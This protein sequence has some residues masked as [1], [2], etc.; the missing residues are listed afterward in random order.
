MVAYICFGAVCVLQLEAKTKKLKKVWHKLQGAQQEIKD[1][2]EEFQAEKEDMLDTIREL[3]KQLKLK[4]LLLEG[5]VPPQ[6]VERLEAR[7]VWDDEE[8]VWSLRRIELAGNRV[9]LR[10]PPSTLTPAQEWLL[11]QMPMPAVRAQSSQ[12]RAALAA[13]TANG[14]GPAT[15]D[16]EMRYKGENVATLDLEW[17]AGNTENYSGAAA[18][19]KLGVGAIARSVA[20]SPA[21]TVAQGGAGAGGGGGGA[22]R[23]GGGA[24][25]GGRS[26]G[27]GGGSGRSRG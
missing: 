4:Q 26:G 6:E 22:E 13:A 23:G 8:D 9:R 18:Q 2:K 16:A 3:N 1:L 11:T 14:A 17:V 20:N 21:V 15:A 24:G 10:R 19:Q 5:F 25:G 27:A 12:A 7:A